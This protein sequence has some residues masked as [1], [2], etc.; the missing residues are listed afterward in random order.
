[1]PPK[2]AKSKPRS[3]STEKRRE[4]QLKFGNFEIEGKSGEADE[5]ERLRLEIKLA[6]LKLKNINAQVEHWE[7]MC[8]TVTQLVNHAKMKDLEKSFDVV[9]TLEKELK[10]IQAR[11]PTKL[12]T[13]LLQSLIALSEASSCWEYQLL[14]PKQKSA[15]L[16]RAK[17]IILSPLNIDVGR[18]TDQYGRTAF[19]HLASI[20][21]NP[22]CIKLLAA[23]CDSNS[24][25]IDRGDNDGQTALHVACHETNLNAVRVLV[26]KGAS[27]KR[28][29]TKRSSPLMI[30]SICLKYSRPTSAFANG[31]IVT[32]LTHHSVLQDLDFDMENLSGQS[33][34]SIM[35]SAPSSV[36]VSIKKGLT[37]S[38]K[39]LENL[40]HQLSKFGRLAESLIQIVTDYLFELSALRLMVPSVRKKLTPCCTRRKDRR[41]QKKVLKPAKRGERGQ[42]GGSRRRSQKTNKRRDSCE[43][44][45]KSC[46]GKSRKSFDS[47]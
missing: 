28:V 19:H 31:K 38:N 39:W 14:T 32:F 35:E 4:R 15:H 11:S 7:T 22:R 33:I 18:V 45:R 27:C 40:N 42:G 34:K 23:L 29:D 41:T 10:K 5:V 30:A 8:S 2:D 9:K 21:K 26:K 6:E 3:T 17:S 1:M 25:D 20:R 46:N 43:C 36:G 37:R 12:A 24:E 16:S 47:Y 13:D 44:E